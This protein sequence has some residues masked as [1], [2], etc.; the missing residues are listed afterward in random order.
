MNHGIDRYVGCWVSSSE[1]R[2][3]IYRISDIRAS[4]DF[5]DSSGAPVVRSYMG[6][7]L[8]LSMEANFDDYDGDFEV[9]LWNK[10]KGFTLHLNYEHEYDLDESRREAL[11]FSLSRFQKDEF[12]ESFF[13]LF[14]PMNH[15]VRD[16]KAEQASPPN[17]VPAALSSRFLLAQEVAPKASGM[18]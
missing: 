7:A 13:P 5:L 11:V 3:R 15:F 17:P 1:Q 4:V 18:R 9:D 8:A 12:L 14:G 6:D 10:D 2:L 16:K